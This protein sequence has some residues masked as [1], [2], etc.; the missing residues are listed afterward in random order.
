MPRGSKQYRD[1][2]LRLEQLRKH[3][4]FFVP[5][6]PVSKL[7]YSSQELDLA[8][9]Y[10]VL[11][12]AEIEAFCEDLVSHRVTVAKS[13]YD[14]T[15]TVSPALRKLI[16]HFVV[17]KGKSWSNVVA[18]SNAAVES[19]VKAHKKTVKNNHGVKR[20]NL[21]KLLYPLGIVE[22]HLNPTW[23]A[24][25]DSFGAKRGGWAH[26]SVRAQ[27]PPDPL[28]QMR[29]VNQLLNGLSNLDRRLARVR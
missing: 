8:M 28:T 24:D 10:V 2:T 18:P 4:L 20:T 3:L 19:A 1:L 5:N 11:A 25:M 6:P 14:K 16:T 12:H 27:Q 7:S 23:L 9:A 22:T 15:G 21:E 29:A 26:S 13:T 17:I